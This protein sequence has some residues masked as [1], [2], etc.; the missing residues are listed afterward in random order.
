VLAAWGD[1][2]QLRYAAERPMV[3]DNFGDDVS[4]R[5]FALAERYFAAASEADALRI[6]EQLRARY[7]VVRAGGSGHSQGYS[8]RSLFARLHKLRGAEGSFGGAPG[9][10]AAHVPALSQHR[11]IFDADVSWGA[12]GG[13]RPSYKVFEIVSGARI[14]GRAAPG[15]PVHAELRIAL[16]RSGRMTFSGET[17]AGPDGRYEIVVPYANDAGGGPIRPGDAYRIRSGGRE[18][19]ISLSD[20]QVREGARVAAPPLAD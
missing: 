17:Y 15:A 16:G 11:L 9:V 4:E 14:A 5:S 10:P 7:V 2:H 20:T 18:V 13:V 12:S 1:G 6:A 3:Q 19:S 8:A